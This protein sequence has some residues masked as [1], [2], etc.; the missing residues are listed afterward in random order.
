MLFVAVDGGG[1]RFLLPEIIYH[2][3]PS[4]DIIRSHVFRID[5]MYHE[6]CMHNYWRFVR[7]GTSKF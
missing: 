3:L 4:F 1:L 7:R 6:M 5:V 2:G